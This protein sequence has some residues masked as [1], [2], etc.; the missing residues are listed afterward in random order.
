MKKLAQAPRA[1][2]KLLSLQEAADEANVLV[3]HA[4][5]KLASARK[6]RA[7]L[8]GYA[9]ELQQPRPR[10]AA[11]LSFGDGP[12][13][14]VLPRVV[15]MASDAA[16]VASA[17]K[18]LV[19]SENEI[20]RLGQIVATRHARWTNL[21]ETVRR[22]D[23]YVT[24]PGAPVSDFVGTVPAPRKSN[25]ITSELAE[26]RDKIATLSADLHEARSAPKP[27]SEMKTAVRDFVARMGAR[28]APA[29]YPIADGYDPEF[30][31]VHKLLIA[32]GPEHAHSIAAGQ[33]DVIGLM[34]WLVPELV[35]ARLEGGVSELS[36]DAIALTDSQ[37][38]ERIAKI[39]VDLLRLERFEESLVE[40]IDA[41]RRLEADVRAILG[42]KEN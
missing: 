36:D 40:M 35:V 8:E 25:A 39:G 17:K 41:D 42:I 5:E 1:A 19:D 16:Q 9:A 27:L 26:V 4:S 34:C 18:A 15:P 22:C 32:E 14:A 38:T 30:P 12:G 33:V 31:E 28:G 10:E 20:A 37:R 21:A 7:D 3:R 24:E 23:L 11:G 2:A 29:V 13:H 6:S